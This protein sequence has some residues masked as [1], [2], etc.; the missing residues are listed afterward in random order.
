MVKKRGEGGREGRAEIGAELEVAPATDIT[1]P[2]PKLKGPGLRAHQ[3][4]PQGRVSAVSKPRH[5]HATSHPPHHGDPKSPLRPPS[6]SGGSKPPKQRPP[7]SP[8][9]IQ[10]A[11]PKATSP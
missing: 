3:R 1:R 6:S 5:H 2:P 10:T 8:Q 9:V 7:P 4:G 11:A